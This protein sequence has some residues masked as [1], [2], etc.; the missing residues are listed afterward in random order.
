VRVKLQQEPDGTYTRDGD[1]LH[2]QLTITLKEA[3]LGFQRTMSKCSLVRTVFYLVF[4]L[5][6]VC[7]IECFLLVCGACC[8]VTAMGVRCLL[9]CNCY[10]WCL[11]QCNC[12]G[13]CLLQC[14]CYGSV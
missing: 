13:W 14:Y 10:G 11:L 7:S 9:Q 12:Y 2:A 3:L 6:S 5:S 1:H 4:V 8:S